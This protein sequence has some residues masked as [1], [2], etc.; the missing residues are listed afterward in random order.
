MRMHGV[1]KAYWSTNPL[2]VLDDKSLTFQS[3]LDHADKQDL[4]V[5]APS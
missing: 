4:D 5:W 2:A 1:E 3:G